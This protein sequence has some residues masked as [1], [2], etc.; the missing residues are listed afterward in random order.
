MIKV[1]NW[2][3]ITV[4]YYSVSLNLIS[5]KQLCFAFRCFAEFARNCASESLSLSHW[6][7]WLKCGWV[8]GPLQFTASLA[9]WHLQQV[10]SINGLA[11]GVDGRRVGV[12]DMLCI[13]S[14]SERDTDSLAQPRPAVRRSSSPQQL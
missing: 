2:T 4:I 8:P 12:G 9:P 1:F 13:A 11:A 3:R 5:W 10:A 14:A 6:L 7:W